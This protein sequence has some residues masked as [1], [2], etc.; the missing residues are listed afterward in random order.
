ME[1]T[2][3]GDVPLNLEMK[4]EVWDSPNSAGIV[5]DAGDYVHWARGYFPALA[6]DRWMDAVLIGNLGGKLKTGGRQQ[7]RVGLSG[8]QLG[9]AGGDIATEQDDVQVG[10]QAPQLCTAPGGTGADTRALRQRVDAGSADQPVTDICARQHGNDGQFVRTDGFDILHRMDGE[11]DIAFKQGAIQLLRPQGLAADLC[12]RPVQNAVSTGRHGDNV[13]ARLV[14]AMRFQK[15][16]A[17]QMGLGEGEGR[18][19]SA[20]F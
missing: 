15:G 13:D 10:P 14:P 4:L 19:A 9:K 11:I 1:G 3:F 18:G 2:T 12:Q 17:H 16:I 8:L 20:E 6:P 5:I 7:G